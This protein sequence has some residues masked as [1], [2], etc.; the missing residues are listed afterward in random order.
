M[1]KLLLL[2]KWYLWQLPL[3]IDVNA[4][5]RGN[6]GGSKVAVH[7]WIQ[8]HICCTHICCT[9]LYTLTSAVHTFTVH[10][11]THSHLLYTV[12]HSHLL[13]PAVHTH[14]CSTLSYTLSVMWVKNKA[15]RVPL[16]LPF[17]DALSAHL[18]TMPSEN[19]YTLYSPKHH[20]F[21]QWDTLYSPKHDTCQEHT[22]STHL[23]TTP[24]MNGTLSTHLN[25]TPSKKWDTL[26]I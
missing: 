12:V 6:G 9:L 7:R 3:M 25:T 22:L 20:L 21:Q 2:Q 8:T 17:M 24:S 5:E 10:C 16:C 11:C 18:N 4:G 14:I 26:L 13:Y 19:R 23:N 15:T 1:T